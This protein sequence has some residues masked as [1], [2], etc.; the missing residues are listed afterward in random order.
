MRAEIW[1]K[2]G[3]PYCVRAKLIFKN[4]GI[5]YD[6]FIYT[7]GP[8]AEGQTRVTR[9]QVFER[10][11]TAET[12]PQIYIDGTYIGGHDDLVKWLTE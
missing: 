9:E 2:P 3:C 7:D 8:L 6:E 1:S 5:E 11:P 10:T 4:Y 12:F